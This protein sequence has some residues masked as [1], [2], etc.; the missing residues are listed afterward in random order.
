MRTG[1]VAVVTI[2]AFVASSSAAE[3]PASTGNPLAPLERYAGEWV[4]D[5]TWSDGQPLHARTVYAWSLDKRIM[6]TRT[7]VQ[8]KDGGEYQRYESILAWHP[9]KKSLFQISFAYDSSLTETLIE[10]KDADTLHIGWV[11]FTPEKPSRVRQILKF[12]DRDHFQ[13][14]VLLQ[15]GSQWKQIMDATWKRKTEAR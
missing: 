7:F 1:L 8:K 2:V 14:V 13:W 3:Q 15:D 12:Q 5:G 10:S 4:V 6:T 9:E 11:P